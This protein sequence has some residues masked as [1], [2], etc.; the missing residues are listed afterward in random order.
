VGP[1]GGGGGGRCLWCGGQAGGAVCVCEGV[2]VRVGAGELF[3]CVVDGCMGM[4]WV[5][6]R[7]KGA[8]S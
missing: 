2:C 4:L 8:R 3:M 6:S 1:C 5:V 7:F